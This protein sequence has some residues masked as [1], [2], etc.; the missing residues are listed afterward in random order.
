MRDVGGSMILVHD[1]NTCDLEWKMC[2]IKAPRDID[3]E[4]VGIATD[5]LG[6]FIQF[7]MNDQL[8]LKFAD[9]WEVFGIRF[10]LEIPNPMKYDK[11]PSIELAE[12]KH[13]LLVV[14]REKAWTF[15]DDENWADVPK[16][17]VD[18][19]KTW[20]GRDLRVWLMTMSTLSQPAMAEMVRLEALDQGFEKDKNFDL[21]AEVAEERKQSDL[22]RLAEQAINLS[23][24]GFEDKS[25]GK[26]QK[27]ILN[28]CFFTCTA[29]E[30]AAASDYQSAI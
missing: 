1:T 10:S 25:C 7:A 22:S 21:L 6:L 16:Y 8:H 20:V 15:F 4:V 18:G 27:G 3:E 28:D 12:G 26:F 2:I 17:D 23:G 29:I 14:K 9:L 11:L 13:K 30:S 24:V 19:F 5:K